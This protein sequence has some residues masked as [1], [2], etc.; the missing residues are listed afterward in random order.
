MFII[1]RHWHRLLHVRA[2]LALRKR[3]KS[4]IHRENDGPSFNTR[5][6]HQ[7][8][9]TSRTSIWQEAGRQGILY[10]QP[11]EEEVQEEVLPGHP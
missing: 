3:G 1:L 4:E 10:G 9:T 6:R 8:R 7:E 11:A 2:L 5:A